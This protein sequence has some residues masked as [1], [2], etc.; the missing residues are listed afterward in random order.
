MTPATSHQVD[1]LLLLISATF[2][3]A[4]VPGIAFFYGGMTGREGAARAFR[5]VVAG[6]GVVVGL[7]VLG[8]YGMI[9]G[10]PL[11]AHLVGVPDPGF[12]WSS[13]HPGAPV[14]PYPLAR[15][16]YLVAVC[17]VAVAILGTAPA[18]RVTLRAWMA[19]CAIWTVV[20]LFPACYAVFA[21]SDGWAV[22]GMHVI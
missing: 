6:S 14:D 18:S 1:A 10:P 22:A 8:G 7:A 12:F 4:V 5:A 15:A 19:F 16:G 3:M 21:L 2:T 17:T 11:I 20:V 9:A 13:S